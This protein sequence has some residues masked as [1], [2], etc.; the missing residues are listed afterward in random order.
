MIGTDIVHIPRFE[1]VFTEEF[2]KK[3]F[4]ERERA[5]L[6]TKKRPMESAAGIFAAKEATLK[7]LKTGMGNGVSL[8]EIE[9]LHDENGAP[10]LHFLKRNLSIGEVFDVSISHDGEYA[11]AVVEY[12]KHTWRTL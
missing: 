2:S 6:A 10:S 4:T 9:V 12:L 11:I 1:K 5:Y 7:A 3:Y 8:A